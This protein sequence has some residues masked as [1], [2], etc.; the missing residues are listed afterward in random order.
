MEKVR[1]DKWL[2]AVRMFKTRSLAARACE[3][4]R[5]KCEGRP[6]K[7]AHPLKGGE[8]LELPFPQGPGTRTVRVVGLLDR[9]VAAPQAREACDEITPEDI[10]AERRLWAENRKH[11]QEGEQGRPTKRKRREIDESRGYFD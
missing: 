11:R 8:L 5:V 6:L 2:W 3:S 7:A 10:L 1:L 9:R 4:G